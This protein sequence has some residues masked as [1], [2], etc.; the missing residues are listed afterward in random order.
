MKQRVLPVGTVLQER[1]LIEQLIARGGM[2]AVY[3][4]VDQRLGNVVALKQIVLEQPRMQKAFE[5]E[6]R[7][8]ASLR[9]PALPTVSDYFGDAE[10]RFLVMQH[11]D[12]EDLGALLDRQPDA[13][14]TPDRVQ[15]VMDWADRLLDALEYLHHRTPP[16]IHRDI[17]PQNLKI[18][19]RGEIILLDFG[20]AKSLVNTNTS[21]GQSVRAYTTDYAPFEQIQ[22]TGTDARSDVY[23]LGAT[24][25]HLLTGEPPA[26]SLSRAVA[27]LGGKPDPLIPAHQLNPAIPAAV[28]AVLDTAL[29]NGITRRFSS[30]SLMRAALRSARMT[31]QPIGNL[32]SSGMATIVAAP[33]ASTEPTDPAPQTDPLEADEPDPH[34]SM[35]RPSIT[36]IPVLAVLIVSQHDEGFYQTIGAAV[37][38]A[39]PNS[40]IVIRPG[41]YTEQVVLDK[42]L[43]LFGDG[44]PDDIVIEAH[45]SSSLL[46]KTDYAVVRGLTLRSVAAPPQQTHFAV[47]QIGQGRLI[48]ERC[49][50]VAGGAVGIAIQGEVANPLIWRCQIHSARGD[51]IRVSEQGRG[52]IEECDIQ[53]SAGAGIAIHSRGAPTVRRCRVYAGAHHGISIIEQGCGVIEA[54]DIF[55]NGRAGIELKQGSN[56][57]IRGCT[58]RDHAQGYGILVAEQGAGLIDACDISNNGKAG[59]GIVQGSNPIVRATHIHDERQRGVLIAEHSFGFFEDCAIV[60]NELVGVDIRQGS[61]PILRHCKV[62]QHG[63]VAIWVHDQSMGRIEEC[64]LTGN[65]RSAWHIEE[66]SQVYR[67]RN[68]E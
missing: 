62:Q 7:L 35:V 23:A 58:I 37:K 39:R 42:P 68:R 48:L 54:C 36:E 47:V 60:G 32:N 28:A 11:I 57:L 13:F 31:S 18:T 50:I 16:V 38:N 26:N 10:G 53:G 55:D 30:A 63:I 24:L 21:S 20:L 15:Q 64:D 56:P 1:Y 34:H 14:T 19:S 66:G 65:A 61:N 8:L 49:A 59:I 2:G 40:R 6:A 45:G 29:A 43:E 27:I 9:H 17:K 5:R 44:L 3:R 22:G 12:G 41:V 4:A 67:S 33:P 52:V 51:G 25:Y 46:M